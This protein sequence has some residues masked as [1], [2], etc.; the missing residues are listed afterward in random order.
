MTYSLPKEMDQVIDHD[1]NVVGEL[2]ELSNDEK[3]SFYR[4]MVF[5]RV[6]SDRM[7]ALQRQGRMGTF[8]PLRGQE[9]S[10]AIATALRPD[11]WLLGSY[12]EAL[13]YF[14]KGVSPLAVMGQTKGYIADLYKHQYG[15]PPMQIVLATQ[16]PHAAGVAMGMKYK[17][18]DS[19]AVGV[20]GDGAS[21]EGDFNETLNFA[22][23]Y[24]APLV[25]VVQ[26]N[27]WAISVPR[28]A[29]SA[30][31]YIAHRAPGFGMPGYIVDGMDVLAVHKVMSE[32]VA[33]ARAGEGPSLVELI[34]YRLG[35]HTTADDPTKYRPDEELDYWQ[36]RD[37]LKRYRRYLLTNNIL[38]DSDDE[39][40][41][42]EITA[43]MQG[44]VEEIES[45]PAQDP[46]IV[47][48]QVYE[49]PTAQL[50]QQRMEILGE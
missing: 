21:S 43:E 25:V 45:W 26:N 16:M 27:G 20:C 33:R 46:H 2:P 23:T 38:T 8:A 19:V 5:G 15:V 7:V 1:G 18:T 11:D 37:P 12:R 3:I 48:D 28:R 29:Q 17:G 41:H 9:A 14:V 47:F 50:E 32:C 24:K 30:A 36:K 35:A 44:Y 4:W 22:G 13:A 39:Q 42:E 10:A 6:F 49:R 31:E 34:C 40:L